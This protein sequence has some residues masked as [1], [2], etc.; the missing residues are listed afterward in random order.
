MREGLFSTECARLPERVHVAFLLAFALPGYLSLVTRFGLGQLAGVLVAASGLAIELPLG[1]I[2]MALRPEARAALDVSSDH[3]V[4]GR[5]RRAVIAEIAKDRFMTTPFPGRLV[6]EVAS[7]ASHLQTFTSSDYF[8]ARRGRPL[9]EDFAI[10][11]AK[12][13]RCPSG[14]SAP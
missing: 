1:E 5:T 6:I 14:S 2:G 7:G 12:Y 13:H 4:E 8:L 11:Q 10:V 9:G 3:A